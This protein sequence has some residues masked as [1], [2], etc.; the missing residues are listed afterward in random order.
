VAKRHVLSVSIFLILFLCLAHGQSNT[1]PVS[2]VHPNQEVRVSDLPSL[3]APSPD[4]SALLTTALDTVFHDKAIC[5][6][7]SSA[8][9]SAAIGSR[10]LKDLSSALQGGRFWSDHP[11]K[12]HA[13]YVAP[14]PIDPGLI[15]AT[16]LD[17]H[18]AIIEWKSNIFIVYGAIYDESLHYSG[19]RQYAIRKFL[20]LDPRFSDQ[21][22]ET[23]FKRDKDDWGK[24][25]GVLTLWIE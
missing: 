21:R 1:D 17:R 10:S 7:K 22:R 6:A 3:A 9:E 12:I 2:S 14:G 16:L 4:T 15:I 19:R 23:E 18:A 13:N 5:C 8:L 20:L 11:L 24:V 25:Q